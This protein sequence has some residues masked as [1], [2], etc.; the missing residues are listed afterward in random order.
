MPGFHRNRRFR[1]VTLCAGRSALPVSGPA[2]AQ[3]LG[4]QGRRSGAGEGRGGAAVVG[5]RAHVRAAGDPLPRGTMVH[6][7]TLNL[8]NEVSD[9]HGDGGLRQVGWRRAG[10]PGRQQPAALPVRDTRS[11]ISRSRI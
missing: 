4:R 3:V 7:E 8:N 10:V 11:R 2:S 9:A 5:G 6:P 1:R